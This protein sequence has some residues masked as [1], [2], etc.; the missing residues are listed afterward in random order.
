MF[1]IDACFSVRKGVP[2][3]VQRL[4][5]LRNSQGQVASTLGKVAGTESIIILESIRE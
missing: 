5:D 4:N 2:Y 1:K 3:H